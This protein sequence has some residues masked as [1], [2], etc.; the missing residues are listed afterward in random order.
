MKKK[1]VFLISFNQLTTCF[2]KQ[3]INFDNAELFHWKTPENGVNNLN[4]VWPDII[5]VDGYFSKK[6]YD[7]CLRKVIGL[8]SDQKIFCLTPHPKAYDKTVF[9]DERL[10]V[11]KLDEEVINKINAAINPIHEK[12]ELK[13]IA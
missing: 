10:M 7:D 5:I 4:T 11:S 6:S 9:I 3:H 12:Q 1:K 8:K 13:L 2:W